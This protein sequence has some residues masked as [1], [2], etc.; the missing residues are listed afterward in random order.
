MIPCFRPRWAFLPYSFVPDRLSQLTAVYL[1][2]AYGFTRGVWNSIEG[3]RA[4]LD[5]RQL[6]AGIFASREHYLTDVNGLWR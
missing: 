3:G 1:L 6:L 4:R 2:P 5:P